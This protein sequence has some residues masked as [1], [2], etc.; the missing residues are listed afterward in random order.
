[1]SEQPKP[2]SR[3]K[4]EVWHPAEY[5][6]ADVA[7]IQALE[8]YAQ[9]A[10]NPPIAGEEIM[11]P[12]PEQVKRALDWIIHKAAA[13]YENGFVASDTNG[14]IGAFVEGRRFVGQQIIKL[15]KLKMGA[16]F[17][18]ERYGENG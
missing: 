8:R 12:S 11:P 13:S 5:E 16:F 10:A 18:E 3:R 6:K 1:M 4:R 17:D 15:S 7:A 2:L 14:R 9:L